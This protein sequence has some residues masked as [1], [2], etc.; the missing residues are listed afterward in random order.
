MTASGSIA[1]QSGDVAAV[2]A[3]VGRIGMVLGPNVAR[4]EDTASLSITEVVAARNRDR[5]LGALVCGLR[6]RRLA[7]RGNRPAFRPAVTRWNAGSAAVLS[8]PAPDDTDRGA[9]AATV[10]EPVI[11]AELDLS[12]VLAAFGG[13]AAVIAVAGTWLARIADELAARTG[14]GEALVGAVLVG[15]STSLPGI[16]T[17]V[18]TAYEGYAGL[19]IGNGLGGIAAQ[20]AF[21]GIADIAYRKANLEHTAASVANLMQGG[22]LLALLSVTLIATSLPAVA[23]W[24]V[25]PASV[26]LVAG[27]LF[28]LRLLRSAGTEPMWRPENTSDTQWE[29]DD[30]AG[31]MAG[32]TASLWL[33]FALL[34]MV[35]GAMGYVVSRTGIVLADRSGLSETA[36]GALFTAIATSLPELVI[37]VASVRIGAYNL[38]IGNIIGGNAFDILFLAAA[39]VAYRDGSLFGRFGD[40]DLLLLGAS[41][42]MTT[43]LLLGMLRRERHGFAGIGFETALILAIYGLVVAT[44]AI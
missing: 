33:R 29:T 13:A 21:L 38:A 26:V 44:M 15:A 43:M 10:E 2:S 31:Q 24:G 9:A 5:R 28:G 27:Y 42:L 30:D 18:V 8:E 11:F 20:T 37:A 17:S 3:S 40:A 25:S 6:G 16:V 12:M 34:A 4:G 19:A 23:I 1:G 22:L 39:D 35:L 41:M 14:L 36:V 32:S 7:R